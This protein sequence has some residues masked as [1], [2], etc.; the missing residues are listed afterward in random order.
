MGFGVVPANADTL[1]PDETVT[2]TSSVICDNP[3]PSGI[4]ITNPASNT[5]TFYLQSNIYLPTGEPYFGDGGILAPGESMRV[6]SSAPAVRVEDATYNYDVSQSPQTLGTTA[7][8]EPFTEVVSAS[9]V[10]DC[11]TGAT[12]YFTT[13][14]DNTVWAV[15]AS[16]I[17]ALSFADWQAAGFPNP[18]P[19][20]TDY[21]KYPW[22]PTV[23][24]VTFFGQSQDRWIWKHVSFDEWNRAGRPSARTAGW[25]KDSN[26]YQWA[27]SPQIFVQD[28]GG[29]K[30]ALN[31]SEWAASGFQPYQTRPTEGFVKLS[32]DNN[33]AFLTNFDA[34]QGSPIGYAQW[35]GEGLPNPVVKARFPGDQIYRNYGSP[36]VWYAGPTVN[37]PVTF[38]EWSVMGQPAPT[39]NGIPSRPADKDCPDYP[40]QQAAQNEYR[41]YFEAY[42][43][44]L[45][46]DADNDGIACESYFG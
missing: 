21:V 1:A 4:L 13:A 17:V 22:S 32:W 10:Y 41:Y 8:T 39:V 42:G 43:D 34:G 18:K 29:V 7:P 28:V 25:I 38:Q 40:T 2:V 44:V 37:R 14:Y 11:V 23:S 31:Y 12:D 5:Q 45:L 19:A 15:T 24:A 33:I 46:L 35:V 27:Q 20:P 30:H 36:T 3:Y 16:S 6:A 9:Y 26:Y